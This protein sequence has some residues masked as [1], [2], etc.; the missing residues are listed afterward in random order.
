MEKTF[1]IYTDYRRPLYADTDIQSYYLSVGNTLYMPILGGGGG[2]K[3]KKK[4]ASPW[5]G[6][7]FHIRTKCP[8]H[9]CLI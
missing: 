2:K 8:N 1:Y 3:K 6:S 4:G 5:Q 9:I 7:H